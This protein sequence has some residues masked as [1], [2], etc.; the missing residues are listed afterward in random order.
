METDNTVNCCKHGEQ[1]ATFVCQHL[2]DSMTTKNKVGYN[3]APESD[4][5]KR[6]DAWC[7]QCEVKRLE[8]GGDWNEESEAFAN[9]KL[10]C[11]C[12]YDQAKVINTSSKSWWKFW[13]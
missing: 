9:I 5:N 12:C 1:Q 7:N 11:G 10:V 8:C 6:P 3:S 2:M 13:H 4:D